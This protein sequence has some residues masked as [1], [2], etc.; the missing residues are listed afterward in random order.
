MLAHH[1]FFKLGFETFIVT[2]IF[3]QFQRN[4]CQKQAKEI[5]FQK[6]GVF[7][8]WVKYEAS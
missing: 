5:I 4:Q 1:P 7:L 8:L 3:D 2:T 6:W